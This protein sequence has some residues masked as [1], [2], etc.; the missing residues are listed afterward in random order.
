MSETSDVMRSPIIA[1]RRQLLVGGAA[2]AAVFVLR[3]SGDDA[4]DTAAAADP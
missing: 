3:D 4:L 2:V 1:N